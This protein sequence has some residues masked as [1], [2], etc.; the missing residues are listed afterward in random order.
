MGGV[1]VSAVPKKICK[2]LSRFRALKMRNVFWAIPLPLLLLQIAY[3]CGQ[4]KG[5]ILIQRKRRG[6][7][8]CMQ[9]IFV[10]FFSL[11]LSVVA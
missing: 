7:C 2:F 9:C 4:T 3:L 11:S 6:E 10:A 5:R 8:G 1:F